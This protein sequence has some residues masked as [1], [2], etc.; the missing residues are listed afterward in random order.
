[1]PQF[2]VIVAGQVIGTVDG[3]ALT[4][5]D[6]YDIQKVSTLPH[7]VAWLVERAGGDEETI[8]EA[9]DRVAGQ[10]AISIVEAV[11][12]AVS[13]ALRVPK[14]SAPSSA[15]PSRPAARAPRGGPPASPTPSAGT[16]RPGRSPKRPR[17]G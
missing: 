14:A 9:F 10:D 2:E 6:L 13:E 8:L 17:S 7:V 4:A 3:D 1:M 15:A 16:A 5:R 12:E 11:V